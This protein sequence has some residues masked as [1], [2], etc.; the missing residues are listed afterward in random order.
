VIF[1]TNEDAQQDMDA[2]LP[3]ATQPLSNATHLRGGITS[4]VRQ[5]T[6]LT[7]HEIAHVIPILSNHS[8]RNRWML[9]WQVERWRL[10]DG[11]SNA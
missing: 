4:D 3:F 8:V 1:P 6:N 9:Y 10:S 2:N 11:G 7:I 5:E